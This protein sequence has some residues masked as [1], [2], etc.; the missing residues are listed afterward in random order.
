MT[1]APVLT[2][3]LYDVIPV[4]LQL[5]F[6][7]CALSWLLGERRSDL[8]EARRRLRVVLLVAFVTLGALTLVVERIGMGFGLI[9]IAAIY[10][11]HVA[12]AV[13]GLLV[14]GVIVFALM[15]P[16]VV[17]YIDPER[18][19]PVEPSF[20]HTR[21]DTDVARVRA[22]FEDSHIHRQMGL[23]VR[24]LSVHLSIP[25][26]RL[27]ALIHEHMGFRNFN[28]LLHHY[29]LADVCRAL[30]DP[31]QNTVPVLTLAL[32]AG[33]QSIAPL[34]RAF[35]DQE[36]MTPTEYRARAQNRDRFRENSL[37]SSK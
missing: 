22:A 33:Y 28:T 27:R 12:F 8:V 17:R 5:V 18:P 4:A 25:E 32:S 31:A 15:R 13:A 34:N 9:P 10:P 36:A 26:Y 35:R 30:A 16:D 2:T 29:R 19:S 7:G 23:T 14:L 11:V 21:R 20:D 6:L 3:W 24:D 1:A 37:D